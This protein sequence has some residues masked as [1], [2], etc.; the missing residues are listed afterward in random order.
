[1]ALRMD[2]YNLKFVLD[3]C[4]YVCKIYLKP[5]KKRKNLQILVFIVLI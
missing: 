1:M 4:T 5:V 2:P 3:V